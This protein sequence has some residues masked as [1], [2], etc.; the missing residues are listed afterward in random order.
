MS[1]AAK[2]FDIA[3]SFDILHNYFDDLTKLFSDL[4]PTKFLD[5]SSKSF[6][7]YTFKNF[8]F[9]L[10]LFHRV[11]YHYDGIHGKKITD[12]CVGFAFQTVREQIFENLNED[13]PKVLSAALV[14]VSVKFI[15]CTR[16]FRRQYY[17][18][19]KYSTACI[20]PS[21][22]RNFIQLRYY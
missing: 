8:Y 1:N 9:K 5:T 16:R 6:L 4:Y 20:L 14:P 3:T 17:L 7:P 13:V 19:L 22:N 15:E 18:S 21:L 11:S 12:V 10:T 2:N